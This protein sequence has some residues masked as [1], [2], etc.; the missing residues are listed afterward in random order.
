MYASKLFFPTLREDPA[1][2]ELVSH[3]LML[4]AG[5]IKRLAS[6]IYS[7]LPLGLKILKK[8]ENLIR[9]ELNKID[10]QEVLLPIIQPA[11]LWK[12]T[13]RWEQYGD[14]LLKAQ[15]RNTRDLCFGP[16]HE[17]VITDLIRNCVNSY[18]QLPICLYQIQTKFRD[19]IRPRFGVM[20]A[21]E[22]LM[23]DAYSFHLTSACLDNTYNK[24]YDAYHK[25]LT[26]LN[27]NYRPVLANNGDM[28]GS[29]SHEF[30]VIAESGEDQIVYSET[31]DYAANI[32][33]NTAYEQLD[34]KTDSELK[35][36]RGIEVG[37]IFKLGTRYSEALQAKVLTANG[38]NI[39]M[40]MGCYGIGVSRLMA[41][42]IEQKHDENGIIWPEI[43]APFKVVIIPIGF[44][45]NELVKNQALSLYQLL[46]QIQKLNSDILLDDRNESPGVM[47]KDHELLGIPHRIVIS[48]RLLTTNQ[49][50]YKP[51]TS[52]EPIVLSIEK[53]LSIL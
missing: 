42:C 44:H 8:L 20:R 33:L 6:G 11:D 18:K 31:S 13:G 4:R 25:I 46:Q 28:G 27:L 17:E 3:K 34:N 38:E 39:P 49:V 30:Q 22:F 12:E 15:D 14:L 26:G 48:E 16:T 51:R 37:H 5:L 23:K 36:A 47:F 7:W 10:A 43:I 45:R 1:A 53:L 35:V 52:S 9:E 2:T 50:E 29:A 32:E 40:L 41:A 19:E 21:R 24:M